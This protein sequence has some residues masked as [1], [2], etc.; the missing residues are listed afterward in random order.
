[1]T[2][3]T[4]KGTRIERYAKTGVGKLV[5]SGLY[6]H[7]DYVMEALAKLRL[8][9]PDQGI[10]LERS[11]RNRAYE[12]PH[13]DF[14][15]VRMDLKTGAVRFDEA[16]DF[17]EAREPKIGWWLL[18]TPDGEFKKGYSD[19]IWHHKWAWVRPDYRGFD[20]AQ[21]RAWS[22]KYAPL[23]AGAPSGSARKFAAQLEA[24]GLA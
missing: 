22:A 11:I 8:V 13:F 3:V 15:C 18:S 5:G 6:L 24:A 23:I 2:I 4:A 7:G 17:D 20:V 14:R 21:S 9:L 12:Y 1:M 19:A 10:S 16:P